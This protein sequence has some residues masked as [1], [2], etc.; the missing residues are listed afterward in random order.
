MALY[1]CAVCGYMYDEAT[2]P[3]AWDELPDGWICPVCGN[4]KEFYYADESAG[5]SAAQS[6]AA[7]PDAPESS[8]QQTPA[9]VVPAAA[10]AGVQLKPVGEAAES[11]LTDIGIMAETGQSILEPMRTREPVISWD[12]VLILGAQIAR[13]PLNEDEPVSTR[14]IIGPAAKT[15]LEIDSPLI[16]THMS[17]G[18]LSKEAKL[19]LAR[20]SSAVRTA[21]SSGEGGILP[22]SMEIAYRYIFEYVPNRYS[23]NEEYLS[24]VDAVEIKLG[25]SAKPGMGG[26]LPGNKVTDE[27]S[28]IRGFAPGQD[29]I[30]P[31]HHSDIRTPRELAVKVAW[32]RDATGGKPIGVK[33]AAGDLEADLEA[34]MLSEPDFITID[35]RAGATGAAPKYIKHSASVPTIFALERARTILDRHKR[36]VSLIITGGL[37]VSSDFSK[38]LAMGADA[39]AVGTA[40][41]I[42][43]GCRQYRICHTGRCPMGIATQDPEL[44]KNLNVERSAKRVEN[45][46]TVCLDEIRT[47]ARLTG[48]DDIH[49]LAVSDLCTVN[50]EVSENTRIAHA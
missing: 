8:S 25:Q 19:A 50:S 3:V 49:A 29:I 48:H 46:L 39:V 17:F 21:M 40:A 42:A 36:E 10:V 35:G 33:L 28:K 34:V 15:P 16:I 9:T 30:S 11:H 2:E 13:L 47:F 22:E 37:R 20:G 27:I 5:E 18:A 26:H 24:R 7:E 43:V 23:V 1:V 45:Y 38:A 12:E 44:R 4:G 14:T 32:L 31:A 6:V 41:L